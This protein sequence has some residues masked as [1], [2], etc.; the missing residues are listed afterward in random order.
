MGGCGRSEKWW[1]GIMWSEVNVGLRVNA[2]R[3]RCPKSPAV[4]IGE[5]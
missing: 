4:R 1:G 5:R 3:G 2:T